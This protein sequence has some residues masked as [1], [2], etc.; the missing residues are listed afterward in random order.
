MTKTLKL[1]LENIRTDG[2][3]QMRVELSR[4]VFLDYAEQIQAGAKFPPV[5]VFFDGATYWLADGFHRFYGNREA[6]KKTIACVVHDGSVRDAILW[7]V[8]ANATHGHRR[9]N[10]DKRLAVE[11][12]LRDEKWAGWSDREIARKAM[13]SP[14]F[15]ST[16]RRELSSD[17]SCEQ[18][19]VTTGADGKQRRRPARRVEDRREAA[20]VEPRGAEVESAASGDGATDEE[21]V[22]GAMEDMDEGTEASADTFEELGEDEDEATEESYFERF[23]ELWNDAPM[24]ARVAIRAFCMEVDVE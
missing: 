4:D 23:V 8:G 21:W 10:A 17:D 6:G 1:K 7:A 9:T 20:A 2:G 3:T 13:V 15:V 24:T 12:L 18:P 5:D 22:G 11:T 19:E 16:M 14:N